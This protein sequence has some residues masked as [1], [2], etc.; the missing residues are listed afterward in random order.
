MAL[1][2]RIVTVLS[3]IS[4]AV[5]LPYFA[6]GWFV[7]SL[8]NAIL[9]VLASILLLAATH[10]VRGSGSTVCALILTGFGTLLYFLIIIGGALLLKWIADNYGKEQNCWYK[11]CVVDGFWWFVA[12]AAIVWSLRMVVTSGWF[13][14]C[15]WRMRAHVGSIV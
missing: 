2:T 14:S 5:Y 12:I 10:L 11:H 7:S 8:V 3:A 9:G 6:A 13:F 4:L 15:L 1:N